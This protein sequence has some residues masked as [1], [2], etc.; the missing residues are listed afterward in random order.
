MFWGSKMAM[1]ALHCILD[2]FQRS[3][4]SSPLVIEL[5]ME[6]VLLSSAATLLHPTLHLI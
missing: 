1:N 2:L 6:V 3:I 5:P 4:T